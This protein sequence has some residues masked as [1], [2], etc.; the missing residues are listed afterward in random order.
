LVVSRNDSARLLLAPIP[1]RT[2]GARENPD[3]AHPSLAFNMHSTNMFY[4]TDGSDLL[5]C[6]RLCLQGLDAE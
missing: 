1:D 3:A 6:G 4:Y 2:R 5:I